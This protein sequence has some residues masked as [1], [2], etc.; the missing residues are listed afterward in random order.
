MQVAISSGLVE[1]IVALA[2]AEPNREVCGL[3]VG[4]GGRVHDILPAPNV[5]EDPSR[6][7]EVDP[8]VHIEAIRAARAGGPAVIGCYHSHPSGAAAPSATDA[9][10]IGRVGDYWLIC[11]GQ[12]VRAWQ[13]DT[14]RSFIEVALVEQPCACVTS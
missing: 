3:L 2:A 10:M 12:N 13:A 1:R 4:Q 6:R 11:D 14:G 5:A 7:F 9:A 8:A